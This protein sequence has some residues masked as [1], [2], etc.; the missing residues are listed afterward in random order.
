MAVFVIPSRTQFVLSTLLETRY[1][2]GAFQDQLTPI[3][4]GFARS[5]E[6]ERKVLGVVGKLLVQLHQSLNLFL[7][8]SPFVASL[9]I[10][11]RNCAL[12]VREL[13]LQR[14]NK[15]LNVFLI[16]AMQP[17]RFPLENIVSKVPKCTGELLLSVGEKL[18]LL[19]SKPLLT[20]QRCPQ[21]SRFGR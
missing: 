16:Q 11:M 13:L 8:D 7:E 5:L 21:S 18:H 17:L 6:S 19:V 1:F 10:Q 3:A 14:V 9:R 15:R 12:E 2:Q 4:L 20:F